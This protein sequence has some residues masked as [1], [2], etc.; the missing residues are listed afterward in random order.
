MKTSV[1]DKVII[2]YSGHG[3]LSDNYDYYLSTYDVNFHKPEENGLAYEELENLVDGVP[4]RQ[5]LMMIDACH[6]GEVDKEEMLKLKK[7]AADTSL[8]LVTNGKGFE[9]DPDTTTRKLGTQNSFELM[10]TLFVNVSRGTGTTVIAA[11]SGTQFAYENGELQNGVFT[12]CFL[13][14]MRTEKTCT[15]QQMKTNVGTKVEKLTNGLQ[16]PTSRTET[17]GYD[18]VLW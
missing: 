11:A 13:E 9:T 8:H 18:W 2:A 7:A 15:V 1:N 17:S 5:K 12:Y 4:A 3:L 14:T 6:S 10:S 16:R